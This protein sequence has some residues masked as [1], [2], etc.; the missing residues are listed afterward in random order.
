MGHSN[1]VYYLVFQKRLHNFEGS[2][3]SDLLPRAGF[4]FEEIWSGDGGRGWE[5]LGIVRMEYRPESGITDLRP[6]SSAVETKD[7]KVCHSMQTR[8]AT[9]ERI[10]QSVSKSS[11]SPTDSDIAHL[12]LSKDEYEFVDS[13]SESVLSFSASL[14]S[15]ERRFVHSVAGKHNVYHW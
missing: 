7:K 3:F 12:G 10:I 4:K 2:F 9:I 5:N 13:Y 11:K 1:T 14:S 6:R 8:K 15:G